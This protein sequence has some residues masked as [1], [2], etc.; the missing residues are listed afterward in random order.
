VKRVTYRYSLDRGVI[1]HPSRLWVA[2]SSGGKSLLVILVAMLMGF[3]GVFNLFDTTS[4]PVAN[5]SVPGE[6]YQI[7]SDTSQYL[8]SPWTYNTALNTSSP[9]YS[10]GSQSFTVAQYEA[11]S[12]YG[13]TLPPLPSYIANEPSPSTTEAAVIFAPGSTAIQDPAYNFPD[14]PILYF[15]E[16]G[17]YGEIGLQSISGDEFIGGSATGYP[18]PE[19]NDDGQAGGIDN[20]NDTYSFTGG[21]DSL[22]ATANAG[23][24]TVT[25]TADPPAYSGYLT[26]SD[27]STYEIDTSSGTSVTLTSSL[28][29]SESSGGQVWA[30]ANAPIG[31]V[32]ANAAQ[33]ATS[34][35]VTN[36]SVPLVQYGQVVIGTDT[37]ELTSVSGTESGGYTVGV[38]GLD[39]AAAAGTPVSYSGSSG[40]VSVEYLNIDNDQHGTTG[41]ITM[42]SGWTV[43]HNNIHDSYSN[44]PGSGV[45]IYGGDESTIEYNCF[46]RMGD[47]GG[48]GSG[49]GENFDYNEVLQ[50]AYD[51]DPGC[52]C[53]GGGK[54]WG[55]LNTNIVDNAFV[56]DGV[57][58]GQPAVWLDN[59]NTGSLI[60]GNYFFMDASN[61]VDDE[62]GFNVD[63]TDNLFQ[64]D[65]WGSGQG[66]ASNNGGAVNLN[67]TGG[68]NVPGSRYENEALVT[69][70][71]FINN[72]MGVDV[73]QSDLRSCLSSGEGWPDDSAYCSGGFP[74]TD[75]AAAGG[76]YYFSHMGDDAHNGTTTVAQPVSGNSSTVYTVGPEA[77]DDQ[78]GFE[79]AAAST[80]TASTADV[81][82]F[83][84]SQTLAVSST[85]NFPST[86]QLAVG[87][88]GG[89][90]AE[91]SYTGLTG[92]SFTG[93]KLVE[94]SG[95]LTGSVA[96]ST[97]SLA[98][99]ADTTNVTSF[100]GSGTVHA[101]TVGFP[102]SGQIRVGTS[103]SGGD[104]GGGYT[105]AVLSYTGTTASTFTGVSLVRGSGTLAGPIEQVQ[106]YKVT[107]ETC[108]A[109]DCALTVS[110]SIP[111]SVATNTEVTNAGTCSLYA[112]STATPTSPMAPDGASYWDGCQW[113]ARDV[114]VTGNTFVFQPTVIAD[115]APPEGGGTST[116]CTADN[117][118]DCGTNF[119]AFQ[120]GGEAPFD[121][122]TGG[123]AMMS[124]SSF[125]GCPGWDSGCTTDP[126][127]NINALS[128]PPDAAAGNGET[129][130]NDVW[131]DNTYSG[132]W[133]WNTVYN[134]G[135]C[136]A[137]PTD[138][139][140]GNT[141]SSDDCGP[142]SFSQWQS[143]WQQ[144][145]GSTLDAD[146]PPTTPNNVSASAN[147]PTSVTVSW[148]ASDDTGGPGLGG[149]YILRNGAQ[150]GSVN[151]ST[152]SYTDTGLTASTQYS[153]TVEAYDTADPPD[154]S[155]ASSAATATTPSNGSP[156]SVSITSPTAQTSIHGAAA[157]VDATV[158]PQGGATITQCQLIING[159]AVQTLTSAPY[160][161][162]FSTTGYADGSYT[163]DVKATDS[164]NNTTTTPVTVQIT[165][166]DFGGI[167]QVGLSDLIIL[168]EHYGQTGIFTYA[169]GNMT[170]AT[171]PPEVNLSDLIILGKNYGYNDGL[172]H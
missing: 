2:L 53:S 107:A 14:T 100:M 84:G 162:T 148:S 152:T 1:R 111:S 78:I 64:D 41:T 87:T 6:N 164:N 90:T 21:G 27:G 134:Y 52:G 153:Y 140:T 121:D 7:C 70:N 63:I 131:S 10:D 77:I 97:P 120:V 129:P 68:F 156:P 37:Y 16:G 75:T 33:G 9:D 166:G 138:P 161:F 103:A 94:G 113:E 50:S 5:Y 145:Q 127:K 157:T 155:S 125:T 62:T 42:G 141:M 146:P 170:G 135:A 34:L 109:N 60:E 31:T 24:T 115:S 126:L 101:S 45:A 57:G 104:G 137:T 48:G 167:G 28:T 172:G 85:A 128:A 150:V 82:T 61:A 88:T 32:S 66:G 22:A 147:G 118:D 12:G 35:S 81:T 15:F 20:S 171:T 39:T 116:A 13:T 165:N 74:T 91:L 160:D 19:F 69:N 92:A 133:S 11:L 142:I 136:D 86:G 139:T 43:E 112:T 163:L 117:A 25:L 144:D 149:Y 71:Y 169:Q 114:S 4:R 30:T 105:G 59:G 99:T 67:S 102:S 72:W 95:A 108:Y 132:P 3:Y 17:S 168:G 26:F 38:A 47:Y 124:S 40:N 130:Y 151:A 83:S 122:E 44:G 54:W 93:V 154:V 89:N 158:T 73:W 80:S 56:E 29:S 119:M 23:S 110:P 96:I 36:S 46:A 55:T 8:T 159:G 79:N 49:T 65:G 98:T 143:D 76:Q 123:N 58:G 106:P 18:E 51:A